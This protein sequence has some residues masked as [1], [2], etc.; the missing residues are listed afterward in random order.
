MKK[1]LLTT[2]VLAM[3]MGVSGAYAMTGA[4]IS[5]SGSSKWSYNA[6]DDGENTGGGNDSSFSISNSVTVASS[7]TSDSGLTYGTSLTL[8]T[9]GGPV[10]DDGMK[11]FVKG[12]FGEIRSGTGTAGDSYGIDA[13]G[14]VEGEKSTVGGSSVGKGSD[15]SISYFTP[16]IS[17]IEAAISYTDAG[18]ESKADSSEFGLKFTTA[19]GVG[20]LTFQFAQANTSDNGT[21]ANSGGK[22]TSF[23]VNLALGD[24]TLRAASNKS[25]PDGEDEKDVIDFGLSYKLNSDVVVGLYNRDGEEGD[26][27][28]AE[29]GISMTYTIAPGLSTNVA[30]TTSEKGDDDSSATTAYIKVAF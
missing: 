24:L 5:L 23:G 28:L 21:D 15:S 18:D 17:G 26:T 11:L 9:S 13:D 2:T 7:N 6:V 19:I 27:E 10:N 29:T 3:G 8:D 4:E 12:P 25:E 14:F 20:D 30:Y 1:L 16:S 22:D